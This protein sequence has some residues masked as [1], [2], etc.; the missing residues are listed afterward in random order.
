MFVFNLRRIAFFSY[1][2]CAHGI[3]VTTMKWCYSEEY[4]FHTQIFHPVPSLSWL[5]IILISSWF[6]FHWDI[7]FFQYKKKNVL[8]FFPFFHKRKHTMH[9]VWPQKLYIHCRSFFL[10]LGNRI[11]LILFHS[12]IVIHCVDI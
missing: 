9:A 3:K 6:H 12:Y 4:H 2:K 5:V 11:F 8:M 7:L 10:S 1:V